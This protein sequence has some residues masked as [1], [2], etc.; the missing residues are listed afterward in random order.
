[1]VGIGSGTIDVVNPIRTTSDTRSWVDRN[2]DLAPQLDELGPSTGFNLG[3]TNRY[4]PGF[5]RPYAAEYSVE[6]EQQLLKDMVFSAAYFHRGV[7]RIIGSMNVAVPTS[8]YIPLQV[9][10]AT[11][12]R[13]VTVYNQDPALRGKFD[14]VWDNFPQLDSHFNGLDLTLNKRFDRRWMLIGGV[15]LGHNE[16]D[17]F[18]TADLNNPNY[19]FRR[20]VLGN[21]V[22]VS[23]KLSGSYQAPYGVMVG[24]AFQHYTGFPETTSVSVGATTVALTQVT[25]SIVVQPRGTTRLPDVN[26]LDMNVKKIV[27]FNNRFS[28]QPALEV[29]NLLNSNAIQARNT[30]LG[31]AYFRAANIVF[32]RMVKFAVNVNF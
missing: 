15:S 29:F 1:M 22:P 20:G 23:L 25:Q 14:V 10:E 28:A 4:R 8:S 17:I 18:G 31:P 6:F 24:A 2:G 5:K 21:D 26:L 3:T 13:Q 11:S 32:G 7:R 30:V 16:G 19:Q 12:G 9:V 27:R